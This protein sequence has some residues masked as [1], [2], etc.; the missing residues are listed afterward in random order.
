MH[1]CSV[2]VKIWVCKNLPIIYM[3]PVL[4]YGLVNFMQIGTV[5]AVLSLHRGAN[6]FVA[7]ISILLYRFRSSPVQQ[8]YMYAAQLLPV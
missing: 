4:L 5:K 3:H 6:E 2:I 1:F 8:N 7:A